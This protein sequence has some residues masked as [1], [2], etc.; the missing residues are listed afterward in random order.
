MTL[1][2]VGNEVE[3]KQLVIFDLAAE[4]YGVDIGSVREIIRMQKSPRCPE[5]PISWRA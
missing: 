4:T 5:R 3:E 2:T 1:E